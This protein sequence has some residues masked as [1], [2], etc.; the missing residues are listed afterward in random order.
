MPEVE[1]LSRAAGIH[2][3]VS[4]RKAAT[5]LIAQAEELVAQAA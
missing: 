5:H 4:K 2:A 3:V 1:R